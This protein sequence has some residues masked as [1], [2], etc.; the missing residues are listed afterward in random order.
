MDCPGE[1][2][3]WEV[4]AAYRKGWEVRLAYHERLLQESQLLPPLFQGEASFV[5]R[6]LHPHAPDADDSL[7]GPAV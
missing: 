6:E 7:V 1:G 2:A 3:R 4:R 5:G